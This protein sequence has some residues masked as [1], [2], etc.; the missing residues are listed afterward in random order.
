MGPSSTPTIS[1]RVLPLGTR[2]TTPKGTVI[3]YAFDTSVAGD[4]TPDPGTKFVAADVEGCAGAKA[5]QSTGLQP[6]SFYLQVGDT[7]Y[8]PVVPGVR[9]PELHQTVLAPGRCVRGWVTFQI[10][11]SAKAQYLFVRTVP[12]IAW[13]LPA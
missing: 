7:A 3:A 1:G 8:H 2:G 9:K 13:K 6:E 5:D 4:S 12:R 10:P 11:R